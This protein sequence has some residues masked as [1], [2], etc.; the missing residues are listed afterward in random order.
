MEQW[1]ASHRLKKNWTTF[2]L[3]WLRRSTKEKV[4]NPDRPKPVR[5]R[6]TRKEGEIGS[7]PEILRAMGLVPSK[8]RGEGESPL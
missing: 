5:T 3:G 7:L 1:I 6:A 2:V 8:S 4:W